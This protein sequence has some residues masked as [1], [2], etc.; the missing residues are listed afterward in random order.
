MRAALFF[1]SLVLAAGCATPPGDSPDDS[2]SPAPTESSSLPKQLAFYACDELD[3]Y[4]PADVSGFDM[5][6]LQ[7]QYVD[8]GR[9]L[10][11]ILITAMSCKTAQVGTKTIEDPTAF[12]VM[13]AVEPSA[14]LRYENVSSYVWIGVLV[15]ESE[16]LIHGFG[17]R[18]DNE[19]G[20]VNL[21]FSAA[22]P[23]AKARASLSLDA[24]GGPDTWNSVMAGTPSAGNA[25]TMAAY[26]GD[27]DKG[28]ELFLLS[29]S[30]YTFYANGAA[31]GAA[32]ADFA[33]APTSY[34]QPFPAYHN[35]GYDVTFERVPPT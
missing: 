34:P 23:N 3:F 32:L 9:Q 12:F 4:Y 14:S 16:T 13:I 29:F 6:G 31:V 30:D 21:G 27:S 2:A 35:L 33:P 20:K 18:L 5:D 8:A 10:A 7:P 25:G 26:I 15:T 11:N 1:A 24:G 17:P 19:T 28:L 22:G